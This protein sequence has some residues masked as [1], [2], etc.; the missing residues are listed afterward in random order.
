[1]PLEIQLRTA[2][3]HDL[4]A[5]VLVIGVLQVGPK[6]G[7][8]PALK[9]IDAALA[10]ALTKLA[11][12]E[13]FSGKRDQ[14]LS[15]ATLGR[16]A[17]DKLV[18]M[19]LGERRSVGA[20]EMRTFAAKAARTANG[21]KAATLAL[22]L[23]PGLEGE[24]R[25]VCEGLELGAYRFTKYLTG[26]RKPK[27]ALASVIVCSGG[28]FKPNAKA[29]LA[30][31]QKVAAAVNFSRDLSN[32]PPNV[33][34]PEAFAAAA[35]KL[36]KENGLRVLTFDFKEIRRRGMKLIDAVGRGSSREPRL[37]HI[38]WVPKGAKRKLVFVGKGITFDTGGISIKPAAGMG[39]MKHDMSGAA[40]VVAL[41]AAVA[42][43]KPKVEVHAI[44]ACAE[45]MPDGDAYRPGDI[46]GSL[47]GKTV[48]IVN[49]DAEGR[50]VLADALA[51][52]R[53]LD[54]DVIIDN[55]TLTGACVVALG[56]TCSGWYS[57]HEDSAREFAAALKQSGEQMWRM[58]LLEDLREQVKSEVA[59]VKQAGDRY[60]GS[61][62]AALFLRE[63]AGPGRW[64]HCDIAGPAAI[65]RPTSWMQSKGATG[66]GVLTFLAMIERA[67]H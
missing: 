46:W 32:E 13:E 27:T 39:E 22:A 23:P 44:A 3:A 33:L 29:T 19:G 63:F 25:A 61:I 40:N 45:N 56:N 67:S 8:P 7:L 36:A 4:V 16:I 48:E 9:A 2:Q 12:K 10:G 34:Y 15:I 24:V 38:S 55:A 50:L 5:D 42:A 28:R 6:A 54:P 65:E 18:V 64:I 11:V 51:Y 21:E 31:G 53:T 1:M 47:D 52:A 62:T 57:G 59:D 43:L 49:T 66:H 37:V 41:M 60:G 26:E 14:T 30:I 58:P 20:P 35:E 17:A